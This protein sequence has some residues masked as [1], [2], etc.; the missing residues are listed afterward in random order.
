MRDHGNGFYEL[1]IVAGPFN[2]PTVINSTSRALDADGVERDIEA[3]ATGDLWIEHPEN[4][5]TWKIY[6]RTDDQIMH[7]TGEKV[8]IYKHNPEQQGLQFYV[9]RQIQDR[10]NRS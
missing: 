5:D 2:T 7:S 4:K 3:Y 6:G 9:V 1:I 8:S 10:L